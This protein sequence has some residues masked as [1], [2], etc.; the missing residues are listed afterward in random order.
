MRGLRG[1]YY[2]II[3]RFSDVEIPSNVGDFSLI[4]KSVVQSMIATEDQYPYI[5]GQ[6]AQAA[7]KSEYIYY[8]WVKRINGKSKSKPLVLIDIAVSGIVST[9]QIPARIALIVGFFTSCLGVLGG[10]TYASLTILGVSSAPPGIPTIVVA[11]FTFMGIQ[12]FFLGLIGEYVLSIHR[13]IKREPIPENYLERN[14]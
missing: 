14:F 11:V 8:T 4:H 1:I 9:T 3:R 5:R 10:F 2:R 7:R 6:I 13:Q 12:L